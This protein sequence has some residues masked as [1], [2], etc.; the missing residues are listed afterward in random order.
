MVPGP[1]LA[2]HPLAAP[3]RQGWLRLFEY[4]AWDLKKDLPPVVQLLLFAP[5]T[6][7][8]RIWLKETLFRV[9]A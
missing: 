3:P 7:L 1:S 5:G 8:W 6:A 9:P 2:C 4:T